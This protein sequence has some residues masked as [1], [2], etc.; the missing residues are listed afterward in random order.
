[1]QNKR[2]RFILKLGNR[3]HIGCKEL[4]KVNMLKVSERVTQIKLNHIHKIW[5]N[6]CPIYLKEHFDRIIDTELRNCTRASRNNFFL[7]RVQ[8]QAINTFFYSGIKDWNSL[9]TNIKQIQNVNAFKVHVQK[10]L[11]LK[12]RSTETCPFLFF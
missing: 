5:S 1:M 9:P 11:E 8:K 3:A 6:S 7:P 10:N 4:E 12:A 2:I